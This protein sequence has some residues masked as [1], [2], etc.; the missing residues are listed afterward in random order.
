[1][2]YVY[3]I[4]II[5]NIRTT[6]HSGGFANFIFDVLLCEY[7]GSGVLIFSKTGG[8]SA[9]PILYWGSV[10]IPAKTIFPKLVFAWWRNNSYSFLSIFDNKWINYILLFI[11]LLT[12]ISGFISSSL[13]FFFF[14][15]L[16]F[17]LVQHYYIILLVLFINLTISYKNMKAYWF[18]SEVF[19]T[20]YC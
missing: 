3:G 14:L 2:P 7:I 18:K 1:M 10:L 19:P 4:L 6:R 16:F 9:F 15:L 17:F 20:L 11:F 13:L 5:G 8:R 12:I